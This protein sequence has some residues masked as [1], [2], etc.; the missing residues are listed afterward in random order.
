[1]DRFISRQ[2][3]QLGQLARGPDPVAAAV[4]A[5]EIFRKSASSEL[6]PL[7]L[8]LRMNALRHPGLRQRLV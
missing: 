2:I 1:M 7:E 8:E 4:D 3:E 6:V 5:A